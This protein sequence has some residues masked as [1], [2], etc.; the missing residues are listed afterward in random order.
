MSTDHYTIARA[1]QIGVRRSLQVIAI[2]LASAPAWADRS[3]LYATANGDVGVTDNVFA[4]P[5]NANPEA[6][7]FFDVR[8]GV[9]AAYDTPR[10]IH[11]L[12]AELDILEYVIHSDSPSLTFRGGWKGFFAIGPR[13][14]LLLQADGGTGRVSA[15]SERSSPDQT[16]VAVT[17]GGTT[18]LRQASAG[19]YLSY[20]A[21]QDTR[22]T[23]SAFARWTATTDGLAMPTTTDSAE[24]GVSFGFERT[25][26]HDSLGVD[27]GG[28][29]LRFEE[30]APP[31]PITANRLDRELNPRATALWRHDISKKWSSNLDGG[32]VYVNP[33]EADPYLSAPADQGAHPYPIV[34]GALAYTDV[35]GRASLDVRRN[36]SANLLIAQNTVSDR[37]M[38]Q[39]AL[40]L[41]WLDANPHMA[42]PQLAALASVGI[43]REQLVDP[44]TAALFGQ[45]DVAHADVGLSWTPHPGQTYGL[46]YEFIYQRGD[47]TAAS[48]T[49]LEPTFHRD[50]LYFTFALQYPSRLIAHVPKTQ[51]MRSDRS[52]VTPFGAPGA[53]PVVPDAAAPEEA[54]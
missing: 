54:P 1:T 6:D 3:S 26:H 33:V 8:P 32:V 12:S 27:I 52:D 36:V 49:M 16:P 2:L 11:E 10:M 5:S 47:N 17:P 4:V 38:I 31:A 37:A 22:T 14:D 7:V 15:L 20:Q 41:P 53:E 25:F 46:R 18:D 43:E 23:Q 9:M 51:S 42:S 13:T 28:S 21:S 34:G 45:F 48:I 40:P 30:I 39:L 35:W 44:T 24:I 29:Y 50:T 19:E